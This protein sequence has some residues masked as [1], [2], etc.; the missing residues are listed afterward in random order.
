MKYTDIIWDFNGTIIDDVDAGIL[1]VNKMLSDRALPTIPSKEKYREIFCFPII[2]YYGKCGFDFEKEPYEVLAPIWVEQYLINSASSPMQKGVEEALRLF[3]SLG[4][5]QHI[6]SASELYMLENQLVSFGIRDKF[7]TVMGLDNIHAHSKT[8]LA[9]EWRASHKEASVLF[10]GDTQHDFDTA[11]VLDADCA[12]LTCGHQNRATLE[13]C[14]GAKIYDSFFELCEDI[15][16][17]F[18]TQK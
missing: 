8:E 18:F 9:K 17:N 2:D 16:D 12:L 13:E 11:K 3:E 1:S 4:L 6:L 15:K 14:K 5:R 10:I 7:D